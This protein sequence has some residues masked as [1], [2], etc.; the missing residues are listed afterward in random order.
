[1]PR[2][3]EKPNH[4]KYYECK[5]TV[6][7][8]LSGNPIRKSF[9][10]KKSKADAK[11][12]AEDYKVQIKAS[13][14]VGEPF[15]DG[16]MTLSDWADQWLQL[17]K[18]GKEDATYL[19]YERPIRLQI[20]PYFGDTKLRDIYPASVQAFYNQL[21][22]GKSQSWYHKVYLTLSALLS[23]AVENDLITKSPHR[24]IEIPTGTHTKNKR[25]YAQDERDRLFQAAL[26]SKQGMSIALLLELGLRR[27]ELFALQWEHVD[28][29]HQTVKIQQ[30]I[31]VT[32]NGGIL[33]GATK[34]K[35]SV[36]ELPL[37]GDL[38]QY[39]TRYQQ[40]SGFVVQAPLGGIYSP[41]NWMQRYYDPYMSRTCEALNIPVLNP[42]ELRHTCG[43]L[44]YNRTHDIYAVSKF[45]GHASTQITAQVYVHNNV[46][47][48][49]NI[50]YP[51]VPDEVQNKVQVSNKST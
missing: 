4:G 35:A 30:A 36:R 23:S 19:T 15:A 43:T 49:R 17:Y 22:E 8:D 41:T 13:M 24:N 18:A 26:S 51:S 37:S 32:K 5:V 20:K 29:I 11:R 10:S 6:G 1:M 3:K 50:V 25:T 14:I 31:K 7:H 28:L 12:M 39:L 27:E 34:N 9:L 33:I 40:E 2:K 42:H 47:S 46:E 44:L 38:S 48:L 16:S 21:P 45:L